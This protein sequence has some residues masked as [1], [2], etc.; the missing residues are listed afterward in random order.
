MSEKFNFS[1]KDERRNTAAEIKDFVDTDVNG[2]AR[3]PAG[4][5][6]YKE[7]VGT[8]GM[9]GKFLSDHEIAMIAA[10]SE[11]LH[12]G[13]AQ[14]EAQN[15][16]EDLDNTVGKLTDPNDIRELLLAKD[17][18]DEDDYNDLTNDEILQ[19]VADARA[20]AGYTAEDA[21]EQTDENV[22]HTPKH[23]ADVDNGFAIGDTVTVERTSGDIESDW[24]VRKT[25][26]DSVEV[27]KPAPDGN[28]TLVKL[29]ALEDM[30]RLNSKEIE[31][32]HRARTEETP[33]FDE[34]QR[35]M[36]GSALEGES[37][38]EY[39]ARQL[40]AHGGA[41]RANTPAD[42]STPE[43]ARGFVPTP[44]VDTS[45]LDA[46]M[47]ANGQSPDFVPTPLVDTSALDRDRAGASET[48]D[49]IVS[50]SRWQRIHQRLNGVFSG[51]T[52]L[53]RIHNGRVRQQSVAER[54][55]SAKSENSGADNETE[56][57]KNKYLAPAIALGAIAVAT[58][59][60]F[61]ASKLGV[62]APRPKR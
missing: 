50:L 59:V 61:G 39:E 15:M 42:G 8:V 60:A 12:E 16:L 49:D 28:G 57:N 9:G 36:T 44:L 10:H 5:K 29:I 62:E 40:G 7:G 35:E 21:Q 37:L 1:S 27:V 3:I 4:S 51:R 55:Q 19:F 33:M 54:G 24:Q 23:R 17:Y 32:K 11:Q 53:E 26:G 14:R 31:P 41:H 25:Y 46:K 47:R 34:L 38:E 48:S 2:R 18:I 20:E 56:K 45:A 52:V 13:Y 22:E 58:L 6:G 43:D 30:Q